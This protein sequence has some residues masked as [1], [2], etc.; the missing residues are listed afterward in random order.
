MTSLCP[1]VDARGVCLETPVAFVR[2]GTF[3]GGP[4]PGAETGSTLVAPATFYERGSH[5]QSTQ[6][7]PHRDARHHRQRCGEGDRFLQGGVRRRGDRAY[8][9]ARWLD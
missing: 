8:G 6:G 9:G 1:L 2:G 7:L 5:G 3:T 4:W